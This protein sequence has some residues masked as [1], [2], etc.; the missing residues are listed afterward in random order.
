MTIEVSCINSQYAY[1][2][3]ES[4]SNSSADVTVKVGRLIITLT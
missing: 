2:I 3:L 1:C 4:V